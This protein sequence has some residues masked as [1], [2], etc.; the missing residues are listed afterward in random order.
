[1]WWRDLE[2]TLV[3]R[4]DLLLF[5]AGEHLRNRRQEPEPFADM[6]VDDTIRTQQAE[7]LAALRR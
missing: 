7:A 3:S 5:L 1:M 4:W 2:R 6:E